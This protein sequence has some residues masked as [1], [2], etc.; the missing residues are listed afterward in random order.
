MRKYWLVIFVFCAYSS[1]AQFIKNTGIEISNSNSLVT[2]GDWVNDVGTLF[3]NN[4]VIKTTE[5]WTNNGTLSAGS[6]GGYI[7]AY[8]T[9]KTFTPGGSSFGFIV[10]Q[11]TADLTLPNSVELKDSLLLQ[12]GLLQ[13]VNA[14]DVITIGAGGKVSNVSGSYVVGRFARKGS[15]NLFFPIGKDGRYLPITFLNVTGA[16][17]TTS[18][19]VE[20]APTGYTAGAGVNA[21]INFPYVWKTTKANA[22][23]S[24]S[25]V[26][27][28]YPNT[29]PTAA[30]VVVVRKLTGQNRY[31][32][33]GARAITTTANTV[34]V[35]SYSRGLRG[36]FSIARGFKGNLKTDSLAL[37]ALYQATG[38]TGWTNRTNWITGKVNTWQG[39][40]ETGGQITAVN[41]ANNKLT[42]NVPDAFA[43]LAALQ[44]VNLAGNAIT[45]LPVLTGSTGL[46]LL[47]VSGNRLDFGSL[48]PNVTIPGI[49]YSN[50]GDIGAPTTQLLDVGQDY[51]AS[52]TT[53]GIGNTYQWKRNGVNISGAVN[54]TYQITSINR[55]NQGVYIAEVKNA[56]VP[57]LTLKTAN[58]NIF[59]TATLSGKMTLDGTAPVSKGNIFL[60]KVTA[61]GG[62]D[63]TATKAVNTD[64]TFVFAKTILDDYILQG[65][66]DPTLSPDRLLIYYKDKLFWEEAD[67][68]KVQ[69]SIAGLNLT[70]QKKPE[71]P[72]GKGAVTGILEEDKPGGRVDQTL[73]RGRVAGATV[74]VRRVQSAGRTQNETLTLVATAVTDDQGN[75]TLPNLPPAKYRLNIQYPGYPMDPNSFITFDIGTQPSSTTVN[76]SAVVS[77]Q[78]NKIVVSLVRITEIYDEL[79]VLPYPNPASEKIMV[80]FDR[81]V[82]NATGVLF[83]D[84]TGRSINVETTTTDKGFEVK[85]GSVPPGLYLL[86]LVDAN[87]FKM[88]TSK[89]SIK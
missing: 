4:G 51:T 34:K 66:P 27:I 1:Q 31:E 87:N 55:A 63:T 85:V 75:F 8:S 84:L 83:T 62:Y 48:L 47:N 7:L 40:T 30:D 56:G 89:V 86:S 28:E 50:Q 22:A 71:P 81:A 88:V 37:V 12:G 26:E 49:N 35:R 52:V 6:T 2:N 33:M 76:V 80:E 32:G 14:T 53:S 16:T 19:A 82:M 69:N 67:T 65:K 20:D 46:T 38:G 77:A 60:L 17:P 24:A 42:G 41:L 10:K 21:L 39:V 74:S 78:S 23:D 5:S 11:G 61:K 3:K 13:L 68:I 64:G 25:F 72:T 59:A 43:D 57:G 29:L 58:Q 9:V 79:K 73:A 54:A 70:L 15:G 44:T 45:K 18:V 36:I